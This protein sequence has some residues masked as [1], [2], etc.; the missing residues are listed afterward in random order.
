MLAGIVLLPSPALSQSGAPGIESQVKK[1]V[2]M[3]NIV[4]VEYKLGL[5]NSEV[6]NEAEY[7]ESQVFIQQAFERYQSIAD[8]GENPEAAQTL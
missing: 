5:A 8:M 4:K 6:I 3:L 1:I 7:E 2:M